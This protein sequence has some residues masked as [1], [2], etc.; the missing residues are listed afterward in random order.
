MWLWQ[1]RNEFYLMRLN[2]KKI[3]ENLLP[4]APQNSIP[5]CATVKSKFPFSMQYEKKHFTKLLLK[6]KDEK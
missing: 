6:S 3:S 1:D 5:G 4:S 2:K